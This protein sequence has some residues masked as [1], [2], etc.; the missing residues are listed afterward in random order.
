MEKDQYIP[1]EIA[2]RRKKRCLLSGATGSL[3]IEDLKKLVRDRTD[4]GELFSR[5]MTDRG[6]EL[7]TKTK[8]T[9]FTLLNLSVA[10]T[11]L[12][13]CIHTMATDRQQQRTMTTMKMTTKND[14]PLLFVETDGEMT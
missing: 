14:Y 9:S 6:W 1:H 4:D 5:Y 3:K 12:L 10:S 8:L 2:N 11:G 7:T 13:R